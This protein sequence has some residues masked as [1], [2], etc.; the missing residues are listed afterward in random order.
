MPSLMDILHTAM[1]KLDTSPN[2][3]KT[4][5]G[6]LDSNAYLNYHWNKG[7][8]TKALV[9]L[10]AALQLQPPS[11]DSAFEKEGITPKRLCKAIGCDPLTFE[12]SKH[13]RDRIVKLM[14]T[15]LSSSS[16]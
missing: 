12:N 15:W 14:D 3:G 7:P 8:R 9:V 13:H 5:E 2:V 6:F 11:S 10:G 16:S 4:C 1:Q